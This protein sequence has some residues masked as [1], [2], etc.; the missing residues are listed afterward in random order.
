M[1]RILLYVVVGLL[2]FTSSMG[3]SAET[4]LRTA[5]Q[6]DSPPRFF[7]EGG[8]DKGICIDLINALNEKLS[9]Q[10][11][12]IMST[13]T[14]TLARIN[15]MMDKNELDLFVGLMKTPERE[16]KFVFSSVPV[17]GVRGQ[18]AKLASDPFEYTGAMS[19][20]GMRVG[21]L[22][23]AAINQLITKMPD[24]GIVETTTIRES[25]M[26]LRD[27][28][29]DLVFYHDLGLGWDIR[30][31][32]FTGKIVLANQ[33]FEADSQWIMFT[34]IVPYNVRAPIANALLD[35]DRE[36]TIDKILKAYR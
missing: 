17:F 3:W 31:G 19:V 16:Q 22:R 18:F 7:M 13:G 6:Q 15:A 12:R 5:Y 33:P 1:K 27:H 10:S 23:G 14:H 4:V 32:G 28:E 9:K 25:L 21:V 20:R 35:L 2:V 24:I 29:V 26:K 11:I 34:N 36:G 30:D 8:K